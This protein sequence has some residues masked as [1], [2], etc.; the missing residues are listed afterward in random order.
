M[1]PMLV[2]LSVKLPLLVS[3]TVCA[4][5]VVPTDWFPKAMLV[6]LSEAV[7]PVPVPVR[8][9]LCGLPDVLSVTVRLAD[10]EKATVGV[11]VREM[12]HWAAALRVAPQVLF[13]ANCRGFGPV[14]PILVMLSVALPGLE[15]VTVWAG[16]VVP[17]G[18]LP[19]ATLAGFRF[20]AGWPTPV[21]VRLTLCGLPGALSATESEAER[22]RAAVGVKVTEMVQLAPALR[23]RLPQVL[24]WAN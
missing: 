15:S 7:G 6:G 10:G 2:M 1:N 21:P 19:K 24:F 14:N 23:L 18:W 3:V 22:A 5:L 9:T 20:T 8:L 16:L 12:V 13:C 17:T 4:E 11:K